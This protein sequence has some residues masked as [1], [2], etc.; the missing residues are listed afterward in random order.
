M[1]QSISGL[2]KNKIVRTITS[3]VAVVV[4]TF[5][6]VSDILGLRGS[7]AEVASVVTVSVNV[8]ATSAN[9]TDTPETSSNLLPV[10][11]PPL[12]TVT[13]TTS[14]ALLPSASAVPTT[15]K[16][17]NVVSTTTIPEAAIA[18]GT[19]LPAAGVSFETPTQYVSA[20]ERFGAISVDRNQVG[21]SE[22]LNVTVKISGIF[23][24]NFEDNFATNLQGLIDLCRA[25]IGVL[26]TFAPVSAGWSPIIAVSLRGT[27]VRAGTNTPLTVVGNLPRECGNSL[28]SSSPLRIS[29]VRMTYYRDV[30]VQLPI[31]KSLAPGTYDLELLPIEDNWQKSTPLQIT[32][33]G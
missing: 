21:R 24:N 31:P 29:V 2:L 8:T 22:C 30:V 28:V 33:T 16:V 27:N 11:G 15:S 14:S 17:T 1:L 6:F 4:G 32:V 26:Q 9:S 20:R 5:G 18:C 25:R 12:S 19:P 13:S 23:T 7:D 3:I 10:A